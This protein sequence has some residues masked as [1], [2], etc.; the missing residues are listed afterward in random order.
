MEYRD[1]L[2]R[3]GYAKSTVETYTRDK[4][5]F[6][7]WCDQKGYRDSEMEYKDC[8]EYVK[9]LR[10]E[11]P[12]KSTVKHIVGSLKIY[13]NYLVEIEHRFDNPVQSINIRG[14]SQML[15]HNLLEFDELEDLYYS[16]QTDNLESF[17]EVSV[18]IRNKVIVGLMVYQGVNTT[19]LRKLQYDHIQLEKG[20]IYVP[21]TRKSNSRVLELKPQQMTPIIQY[22]EKQR[23]LLQEK[24]K[25]YSNDLFLCNTEKLALINRIFVKL[26]RINHKVTNN[27]QLRAS[28]VTH[29]L[30]NNNI[31]EVQ[32]MS[33]HRYISSTERYLQDDLDN[34][35]DLIENLHPIS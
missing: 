21:S 11:K 5:F 30:K 16:Y 26:K 35:H 32:Y 23:E 14:A 4:K 9:K 12:T 15:N 22:L 13:F 18:A 28:V 2:H 3:Q 17:D 29:W 25:N 7:R 24:L 8:L 6:V 33:G 19:T 20:K 34:L 27:K 31:R 1:Y 10:R